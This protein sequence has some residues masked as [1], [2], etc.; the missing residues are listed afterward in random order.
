MRF[1]IETWATEY[2]S[3][4]EIDALDA[5]ATNV[6]VGV[7]TVGDK[8]TAISPKAATE[9]PE[10]ILFTDGVRRIDARVWVE[11]SEGQS[12]PGVCASYAAG[13]MCCDGKA[14][15]TAA[16][17][18]RG[19]FSAVREIEPITS[20]HTTYGVRR[21]EGDA[22]EQL[23][24][25]IQVRM[26]ELEAK[27]AAEEDVELVIVDGPLRGGQGTSNAV[28]YVKT[29]HVSYLEP[30]QTAVVTSLQPGQR[31]PVF[32]LMGR[33]SRFSWYLRL[34]CDVGH[35]WS[36]IVRCE[37]SADMDDAAAITLADTVTAGLP[38]FASHSHKDPRAPQNLYPIAGLERELRRR[39]G[40]PALL[41]RDL[42]VAAAT[43]PS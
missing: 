33:Y 27:I 3:P 22:P 4:M 41:F 29:H 20:R 15:L 10:K 36:G 9:V 31:S 24:L 40:D 35:P 37:C 21:A 17:V 5:S 13:A 12:R 26:A 42:K 18:E 2:G 7:E 43:Q 19:L 14:Q 23:W 30:E 1:A 39:L 8:W 25:A 34:P 38:R 6:D 28:G 11:D 32:R 16:I